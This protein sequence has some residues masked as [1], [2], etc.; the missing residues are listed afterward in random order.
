MKRIVLL[1]LAVVASACTAPSRD[2]TQK[3]A[4]TSPLE[5]TFE[6][7]GTL[8]GQSVL[9]AGR[10]VFLYGLADGSAPMT[11]EAGT[12]QIARDTATHTIT[13]STDSSR[14]GLVFKW[15][16]ESTSGD[17]MSYVV[18]SAGGEVTARGR[19]VRRR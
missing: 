10:F 15:T 8:K 4:G 5:G 9:I 16:P 2:V 18:M 13:Y 1:A 17:T 19:S 12:Y 14:I 7:V 11:G 6:Y 3:A